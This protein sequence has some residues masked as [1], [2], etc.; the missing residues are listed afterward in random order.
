MLPRTPSNRTRTR[1]ALLEGYR[2]RVF[3]G[4][5]TSERRRHS[6]P[7]AGSDFV[8]VLRPSASV[9]GL[10]GRSEAAQSTIFYS[11]P[12][13]S[14][15]RYR[16]S[17]RPSD[18]T[19]SIGRADKQR[20]M[21]LT[22]FRRFERVLCPPPHVAFQPIVRTVGFCADGATNGSITNWLRASLLKDSRLSARMVAF[23]FFFDQISWIEV[24]IFSNGT[25]PI[26]PP[27][28]LAC[29]ASVGNR[30]ATANLSGVRNRSAVGRCR[31]L[32]M[33]IARTLIVVRPPSGRSRNDSPRTGD[34]EE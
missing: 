1:P 33:P 32:F 25:K 12:G 17:Y 11:M 29:R 16:H 24:M 8:G 27:P 10:Y 2:E 21:A 20:R 22:Q 9:N 23:P 15:R 14:L 7:P 34:L 31:A 4:H 18:K 5:L 28:F 30:K 6:G 3:I 26:G 13:V 19:R